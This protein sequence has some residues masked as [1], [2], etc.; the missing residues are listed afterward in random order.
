MLYFRFEIAFVFIFLLLIALD[1]FSYLVNAELSSVF[2][3]ILQK[4]K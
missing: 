1:L 2:R 4:G 3:M